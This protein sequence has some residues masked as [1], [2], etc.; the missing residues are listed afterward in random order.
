ML[1]Y[2]RAQ[3]TATAPGALYGQSEPKEG[4]RGT[5]QSGT[6]SSGHKAVQCA[7]KGFLLV[8]QHALLTLSTVLRCPH[9]YHNDNDHAGAAVQLRVA[10]QTVVAGK[11]SRSFTIRQ[12]V[13]LR[14]P[15]AKHCNR[16]T[17]VWIDR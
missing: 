9:N 8:S 4:T 6:S 7:R 13:S 16:G 2:V 12:S 14:N 11:K 3:R 5:M 15:W 17:V 10:R 1:R